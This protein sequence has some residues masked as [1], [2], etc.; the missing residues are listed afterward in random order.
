MTIARWCFIGAGLA[1][2]AV[3]GALPSLPAS[4]PGLYEFR[5]ATNAGAFL[6]KGAGN[7]PEQDLQRLADASLAQSMPMFQLCVPDG[8]AKEMDPANLLPPDC[9]FT[10]VVPRKNGYTAVAHCTVGARRDATEIAVE[11]DANGRR[12][13]TLKLP[14][15]GTSLAMISL[16]EMTRLSDDCGAVPP[17]GRR[18]PNGEIIPPRTP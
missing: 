7:L 5:G 18:M 10:D 15:A 17:G 4:R 11:T 2:A 3:A 13:V 12:K 6:G 8:G 1:A 16:Y 14:V 9:S